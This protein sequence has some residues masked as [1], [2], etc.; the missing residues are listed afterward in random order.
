MTTSSIKFIKKK[1]LKKLEEWEDELNQLGRQGW[2]VIQIF[3]APDGSLT[4]LVRKD[5]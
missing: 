3:T 2:K 4:A 5:G 1:T